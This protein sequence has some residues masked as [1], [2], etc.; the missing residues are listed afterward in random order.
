M[1]IGHGNNRNGASR[2]NKKITMTPLISVIIPVRNGSNYLAEALIAIKSQQVDMEIIVVDDGSTD[3]TCQIAESFGCVILKHPTSKGVPAAKNTALKI[4]QGKYILFHDHD[5]VMNENSLRQMLKEL[6][7]NAEVFAVMAQ[8][9]DFL[10]PE[11][12]AAEMKKVI[13]RPEPYFG[14]FSGAILMKKEIFDVIGLFD[15]TLK[16]GDIIEWTSKMNRHNL[17]IKRLNFP[18]VNRR[19]HNSNF[20][21]TNKENEYKDYATILRSKIRQEVGK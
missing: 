9:K 15:E 14:L 3:N 18:A 10:S 5:D 12:T 1:Q 8:L 11:L 19:I 7:E 6:Q 20:G 21:R 4:A 13:I 2:P 17:Q 16:A